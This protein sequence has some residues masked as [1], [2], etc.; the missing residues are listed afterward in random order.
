[1][2]Q[3]FLI[4]PCLLFSAFLYAQDSLWVNFQGKGMFIEHRVASGED[5]F[6]LSARYNAPAAKTADLNKINFQTGLE[7][8]SL[9]KIPVDKFNYIQINS[10][11]NSRP[12]Y[13]KV[14]PGISL[15]DISRTVHVAQSAIQRWNKMDSPEVEEG[16]VLLVGW[17]K[18]DDSK[19]PFAHTANIADPQPEKKERQL[20][21]K[22]LPLSDTIAE[23]DTASEAPTDFD[24]LFHER[25][26]GREL[27]TESGAAVFYVLK[28]NVN[29]GVFYAFHN[30]APRGTILSIQNPANGKVIYAKVI[31]PLPKIS[32]YHNALI[33]LSSNAIPDLEA[34]DKRMFCNIKW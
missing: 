21:E 13:F 20:I 12:L 33:G 14:P 3:L 2:K 18:F 5:L 22:K 32:D 1:M 19:R 8:G 34:R 26:K 17:V 28:A 31:G 9:F 24:R 27:T 29:E 25:N 6:M 16:T 15:R 10:A 23:A 11:V 30:T 7:E 4:F